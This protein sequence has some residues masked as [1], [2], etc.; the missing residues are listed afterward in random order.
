MTVE[1]LTPN[2]LK[3]SLTGHEVEF[4]FGGYDDIDY[5]DPKTRIALNVLFHEVIPDRNFLL[6]CVKMLVDIKTAPDGCEIVLTR[7]VLKNSKRHRGEGLYLFEFPDSES[8]TRA[9]IFLYSD[10]KTRRKKSA[11]YKMP[12][13]YRLLIAAA[14]FSVPAKQMNEY[15][16]R[17]S[18]SYLEAAYTKEYGRLLAAGNA[19]QTLGSVFTKDF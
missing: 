17:Q 2:K 15:C 13:S 14:D 7:V 5:A 1:K 6:N 16:S 9:V 19:V 11:L 8:M 10:R 18:K 4:F 12:D 3:I